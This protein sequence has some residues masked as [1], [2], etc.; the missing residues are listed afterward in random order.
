MRVLVYDFVFNGWD[1]TKEWI[2]WDWR[3]IV[4]NG[5]PYVE[6]EVV[7]MGQAVTVRC[8]PCSLG[9]DRTAYAQ[10]VRAD[11]EGALAKQSR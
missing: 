5:L 7:K 2:R 8:D 11:L 3:P 9:Q 6:F 1:A 10:M 4:H